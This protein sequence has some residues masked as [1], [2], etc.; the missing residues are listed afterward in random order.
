MWVQSLGWEDPLEKEMTTQPN[1]LAWEILWTEEPGG[2]QSM[3]L[4][5]SWAWLSNYTATTMLSIF[6]RA[7]WLFVYFLQRN[8]YSSTLLILKIGCF[9]VV[10]LFSCGRLFWD[11]MNCSLPGSSVHGILQARLLEWVVIPFS[12]GSSQPRNQTVVSCIAGKFFTN[13]AR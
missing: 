5:K 1:I 12:R 2:L 9:V 10:E 11:P 6:S 13:W 4:Q 7:Y 3:G 8:V